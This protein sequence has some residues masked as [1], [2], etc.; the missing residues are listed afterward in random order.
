MRTVLDS[1]R[2]PMTDFRESAHSHS[3]MSDVE[4]NAT[5]APEAVEVTE[6]AP[7]KS[8]GKMTVEDALQTVLKN[9]MVCKPRY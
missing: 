2:L 7:A 4:D 1:V 6:S 9:A 8:G 3:T 5:A